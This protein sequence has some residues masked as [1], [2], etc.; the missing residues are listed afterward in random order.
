[1]NGMAT[2]VC[3]LS[4]GSDRDTEEEE[5]CQCQCQWRRGPP[6]GRQFKGLTSTAERTRRLAFLPTDTDH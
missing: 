2:T 3:R 5:E 4:F 1:V 6:F